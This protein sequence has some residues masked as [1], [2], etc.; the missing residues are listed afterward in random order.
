MKRA[1]YRGDLTDNFHP[2]QVIGKTVEGAYVK[3]VAVE[4]DPASDVTVVTGHSVAPT[5]PDGTRLRYHGSAD[6]SDDTPAD[7]PPLT[8]TIQAR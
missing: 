7:R 8:D 3:C 6:G 5:A 1:R 4:Y 2:G